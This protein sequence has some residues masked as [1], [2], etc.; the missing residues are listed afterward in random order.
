[1]EN[2]RP[3]KLGTA[4]NGP[5]KAKRSFGASRVLALTECENSGEQPV[6]EKIE[7][8]VGGLPAEEASNE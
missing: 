3:W 8:L 5:K 2:V 4:K 7:D 6:M 1:M